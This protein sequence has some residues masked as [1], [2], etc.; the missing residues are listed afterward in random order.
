[1]RELVPRVSDLSHGMAWR[2]VNGNIQKAPAALSTLVLQL[3]R[4]H[5]SVL[6]TNQMI[7]KHSASQSSALADLQSELKSLKTLLISR[8]HLVGN[9]T[10]TTNGPNSATQA[11]SGSSAGSQADNAQGYS[12]SNSTSHPSLPS[13][14]APAQTQAQRSASTSASAA[15]GTMTPTTAAANALL[16]GNGGKKSIP[17]WQLAPASASAS[18]SGTSGTSTGT[19]GEEEKAGE[20][21]R[22]GNSG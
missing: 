18:A 9:T 22:T 13:S 6:T 21:E 12:L 1:M 19:G 17:A 2:I 15:N 7:E 3:V 16:G 20:G 5:Q 4:E 8:Q 10:N 14:P 11:S